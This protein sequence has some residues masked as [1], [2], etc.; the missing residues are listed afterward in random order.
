MIET[1][2]IFAAA[3]ALIDV[4]TKRSLQIQL[5]SRSLPRVLRRPR[6]IGIDDGD[7]VSQGGAYTGESASGRLGAKTT[8]LGHDG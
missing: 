1:F 7:Q 6:R 5:C 2:P 3:I 8:T 4:I